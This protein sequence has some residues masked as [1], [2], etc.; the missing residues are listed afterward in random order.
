MK[1]LLNTMN[2]ALSILVLVTAVFSCDVSANT[3]V[4]VAGADLFGHSIAGSFTYGDVLDTNGNYVLTSATIT[5]AGK[6][7]NNILYV[8]LLSPDGTYSGLGTA[9]SGY[10]FSLTDASSDALTFRAYLD[11]SVGV[12]NTST[13]SSAD[14]G[15][16]IS[17]Y[18]TQAIAKAAT[19]VAEPEVYTTLLAG[20]SLLGFATRRQR[21]SFAYSHSSAG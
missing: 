14:Q 2:I 9:K 3:V 10:L 15:S 8:N 6:L 21:G 5:Y 18:N 1:A 12:I 17:I 7:F 19:T 13:W 4:D 11:S 20:L 16:F